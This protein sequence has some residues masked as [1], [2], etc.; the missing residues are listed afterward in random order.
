M[1]LQNIRIPG[2]LF[3]FFCIDFYS[4]VD[5]DDQIKFIDSILP[6]FT[7]CFG[8]NFTITIYIEKNKIDIEIYV[9][10]YIWM[11]QFAEMASQFQEKL[12]NLNIIQSPIKILTCDNDN[13]QKINYSVIMKNGEFIKKRKNIC[14][15]T[16]KTIN[17]NSWMHGSE[18]A[19]NLY[20]YRDF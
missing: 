11:N 3:N 12:A 4:K 18:I 17:D 5:E 9:G 19:E 2:Y 14:I 16:I 20:D 10:K 1:A 7:E 8:D 15:T 13:T 6:S